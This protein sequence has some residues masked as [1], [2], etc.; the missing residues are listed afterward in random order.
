MPP[1]ACRRCEPSQG[2]Y[3][4]CSARLVLPQAQAWLISAIPR[5]RTRTVCSEASDHP[6][7][8]RKPDLTGSSCP[9]GPKPQFHPEYPPS[10]TETSV[11]AATERTR[12]VTHAAHLHASHHVVSPILP[13]RPALAQ[14]SISCVH[15]RAQCGPACARSGRSRGCKV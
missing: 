8:H 3:R 15:C 9:Q 14:D 1:G 11:P 10:N 4:H 5:A 6:L 12:C 7:H 13:S 2:P